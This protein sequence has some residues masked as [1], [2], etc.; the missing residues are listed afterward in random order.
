MIIISSFFSF[1]FELNFSVNYPVKRPVFHN[2][3][4]P[5]WIIIEVCN[6]GDWILILLFIDFHFFNFKFVFFF[7]L[8]KKGN[9]SSVGGYA[10]DRN[11]G[12]I[13]ISRLKKHEDEGNFTCI[14]ESKWID[15]LFSREN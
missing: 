10:V 2:H 5:G 15:F 7:Y 11:T 3:Y 8:E 4:T 12:T 13:V 6:S 14:A 9:L 1:N